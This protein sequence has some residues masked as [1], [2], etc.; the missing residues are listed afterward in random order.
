MSETSLINRSILTTLIELSFYFN[1]FY[2]NAFVNNILNV[3]CIK[4]FS[5][6]YY[7]NKINSNYFSNF[8]F[9]NMSV[10]NKKFELLGMFGIPLV[11]FSLVLCREY[12]RS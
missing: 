6:Q 7:Y 3:T 8:S 11:F 1:T 2:S 10:L 12:S 5:A 9:L 4:M